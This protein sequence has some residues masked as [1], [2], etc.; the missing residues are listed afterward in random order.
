MYGDLPVYGT[1]VG[2]RNLFTHFFALLLELAYIP[3]LIEAK[4]DLF[5]QPRKIQPPASS[6]SFPFKLRPSSAIPF[7]PLSIRSRVAGPCGGLG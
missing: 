2:G 6:P 1:Q 7:R 5:L 4:L 3:K